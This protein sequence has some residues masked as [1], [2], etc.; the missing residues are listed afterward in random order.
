M[1]VGG[2][3]VTWSAAGQ[4]RCCRRLTGALLDA[5]LEVTM[6]VAVSTPPMLSVTVSVTVPA[7]GMS[8]PSG[9]GAST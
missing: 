5:L 3:G 9:A 8:L 1:T 7:P 4:W 2:T 6:I